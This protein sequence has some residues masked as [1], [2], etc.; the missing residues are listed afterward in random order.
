MSINERPPAIGAGKIILIETGRILIPEGRR[1]CDSGE[2]M[3]RLIKSVA[4][5]GVLQPLSVRRREDGK[6]EL[7]SGGRR[8]HAAKKA[9]LRA[10][11]CVVLDLSSPE[12]ELFALT[13]NLQRRDLD[14]LEE[15]RQ[16]YRL[17]HLHG[18]KQEEAARRTGRSQSAVANKLRLLKLPEDV[19]EKLRDAGLSERH[20]RELLRLCSREEIE[21]AADKMVREKMTALQ[22]QEYVNGLV[23]PERHQTVKVACRDTG[24]FLNTVRR[25]AE[26][27]RQSGVMV[28]VSREAVPEGEKITIVI[29]GAPEGGGGGA[30]LE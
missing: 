16:L 28:E 9:G 11:P 23:A 29:P 14:F 15:A 22:A 18:F 5:Y 12:G 13:E 26:T 10:V 8:L 1:K 24:F 3:D 30:L 19:L 21:D 17:V 27:M 20:A 6:F 25:A 2:A 4:R 7:V